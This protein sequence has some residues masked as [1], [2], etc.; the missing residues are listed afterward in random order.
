MTIKLVKHIK[1]PLALL[2]SMNIAGSCTAGTVTTSYQKSEENFPNPER[3]F[4]KTSDPIGNTQK[5]PLTLSELQQIRKDNMSM[6]R[7][8]YLISEFRDKPISQSYLDMISNDFKTARL[9]GIKMII[10]FTYNWSGGGPDAPASR[11]LAHLDQLKPVLIA[12]Y[13]VIAYMEAGFIGNWGEWHDSTNNL[14][15]PWTKALSDDAKKIFFKI[16]SVLPKERMVAL[17]YN[18]HKKQIFDQNALTPE[19]AFNTSDKARTGHH[20]DVFRGDIDEGGTYNHTNPAIVDQEKAWLNLDTR[21]VVQGG[22]PGWASDPPTYDDCP[23]ALTDFARMHWSGMNVN[24][25][26]APTV[27]QGWK[28][29]GCMEEIKRRFGYRFQ[30]IS[31]SIPDKVKPAGTFSMSFKIT[32]NGWASPYNPRS[33]EVILRNTQTGKQYYLP[34]PEAVRLWMPGT[35]KEVKIVSGIPLTMPP[36]E[37]QVLLNLPDPTSTLYKRPEYSIRFANQNVWETSTGYNSLLRSVIIDSNAA[38]ETYSGSQFLK[39]R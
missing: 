22:E 39:S 5:P 28:D 21:Y 2:I 11:I 33:L 6:I 12:N 14:V 15:A 26:D 36:G 3:G 32:N 37:Y 29:Q 10:R 35:I 34:V 25:K 18:K 1:L 4:Y 20:N 7:R 31:S 19:Q 13:D 23:G 17:R 27:Y 8:Y 24:Q 16:L 38:G 30:L 9:A